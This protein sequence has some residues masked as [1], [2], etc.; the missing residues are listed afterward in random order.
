ML[1]LLHAQAQAGVDQLA[2]AG[3]IG[4]NLLI[5]LTSWQPIL[6]VN[7]LIITGQIMIQ[8][9]G[10]K[11]RKWRQQVAQTYQHVMQRAVGIALVAIVLS[12]RGP[13]RRSP[14]AAAAAA[15]I[16]VAG[17]VQERQNRAECIRDII[18]IHLLLDL[19]HQLMQAADNP[20][21]ERVR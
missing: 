9:L 16:P 17:V 21:V 3:H 11:R 13:F 6:Q 5:H 20:D 2:R 19:R 18:G 10:Q 8:L 7:R 1:I 12:A 4:Q 15:D 14:E